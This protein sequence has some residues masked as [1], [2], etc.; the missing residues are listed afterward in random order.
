MGVDACPRHGA[1][2]GRSLGAGLLGGDR[3][4]RNRCSARVHGLRVGAGGSQLEDG[5]RAPGSCPGERADSTHRCTGL[6]PD[7]ASC[8]FRS[9]RHG[10]REGHR[11]AAGAVRVLSSVRLGARVGTAVASG[12][13]RL[14]TAPGRP[15]ARRG[16]SPCHPALAAVPADPAWSLQ[17]RRGETLGEPWPP[18]FLGALEPQTR[19]VTGQG[20]G[21]RLRAARVSP[22]SSLGDVGAACPRS[23]SPGQLAVLVFPRPSCCFPS[24]PGPRPWGDPSLSLGFRG[25]GSVDGA[26]PD[27]VSAGAPEPQV[28]ALARPSPSHPA[29]SP[30]PSALGVAG[31]PTGP[32]ACHVV[33][34]G[35]AGVLRHHSRGRGGAASVPSRGRSPGPAR[36]PEAEDQ[37]LAANGRGSAPQL[38]PLTPGLGWPATA[39]RWTP[40]PSGP[41]PAGCS[42]LTARRVPAPTGFWGPPLPAD[43]RAR[44]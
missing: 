33:T 15:R 18:T 42:S 39:G 23:V 10:T 44:R 5:G 34:L 20:R 19:P 16:S 6:P 12:L 13:R 38:P 43:T 22:H 24:V 4:E 9:S 11:D 26:Q 29:L 30:R 41:G 14:R 32:G 21:A 1:G 7:S 31:D 17:T 27:A 37:L 40:D 28:S 3:G 25:G 2:P 8:W 35:R 36:P